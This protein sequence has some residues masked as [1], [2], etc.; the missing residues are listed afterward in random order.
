[1]LKPNEVIL[2]KSEEL[3]SMIK[4]FLSKGGTIQVCEK[5]SKKSS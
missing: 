3:T 2:A 4:E 5:K 1:M